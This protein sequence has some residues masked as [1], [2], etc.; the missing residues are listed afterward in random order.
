MVRIPGFHCRGLG[1]IPGWGTEIPLASQCGPK[2]TK[3]YW[4]SFKNINAQISF[5][6]DSN[7]SGIGP[8]HSEIYIYIK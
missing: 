4:R 3:N 1:S 7:R 2:K 8:R 6:M 5:A